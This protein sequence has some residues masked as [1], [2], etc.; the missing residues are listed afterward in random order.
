[1]T[2]LTSEQV[3]KKYKG[4]YVSVLTIY[5]H[6][7]QCPAYEVTKVYATIHENTTLA[8]DVG[9]DWMYRR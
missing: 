9:T 4:K 3:K 1:M 2:Y 8:E 5:D 7:R 6:E